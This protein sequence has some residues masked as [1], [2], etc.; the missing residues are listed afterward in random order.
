MRAVLLL[1]DSADHLWLLLMGVLC[2]HMDPWDFTSVVGKKLDEF[3]FLVQV[4]QI[5]RK[6]SLMPVNGIGISWAYQND[7]V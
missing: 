6:W 3:L 1:S 5:K 2:L 4:D 7:S